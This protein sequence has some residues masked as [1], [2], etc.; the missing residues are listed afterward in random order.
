MA[1]ILKISETEGAQSAALSEVTGDRIGSSK[2]NISSRA[3]GSS[4]LVKKILVVTTSIVLML[5]LSACGAPVSGIGVIG[6]GI[7]TK[8]LLQDMDDRATHVIQNAAA[9][10][11]LLSSKAA[12]DVHLLIDAARQ[13]LHDE[14]DVQWD[15]LDREKVDFLREL[16]AEV[17]RIQDLGSQFGN[18]EDTAYL[19]TDTLASRLPFAQKMPRVRRIEGSSQYFKTDG[20]YKLLLTANLFEPFGPK[21]KVLVGN[22]MMQ[23][24][25]QPPYSATL[26]IPHEKLH[27]NDFQTVEVPL[28][29]TTE[30]AQKHFLAKNETH[31]YE[32]TAYIELYPK[33]P[34]YYQMDESVNAMVVDDTR[35]AVANG[36]KMLIPG[37]GDSGCNAYYNVCSPFPVGAQ[38]I[39]TVNLYD[40]FSGWGGF[41]AVSVGVGNVC[42]VY[43]QHSHNVARNV[44]IDVL[45]HP[46][47][48]E[49][50]HTPVLLQPVVAEKSPPPVCTPRADGVQPPPGESV[51]PTAVGASK[52]VCWLQ[53]GNT[54]LA[55]FNPNNRGYKLA[56]HMFNGENYAVIDGTTD[57]SHPGVEV[58]TLP[59]EN[60]RKS[61]FKVLEPRIH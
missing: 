20:D 13:N 2:M 44:S 34:A 30:I 46:L 43:W 23:V 32:F 27:F 19:D 54:Y 42:Q 8:L 31:V 5:N 25:Q 10:G 52:V 41:G 9:A 6:G 55:E 40:S 48:A 28:K 36:G 37:C 35:T 16:N 12:R 49:I 1:V 51:T 21:T 58:Q 50:Q 61:T 33:Y 59:G 17:D 11:S 14:L 45:Y 4:L 15:K 7:A 60:P 18:L 47:K 38:Y 24:T 56:V 22:E 53:F 29:I 26:T 57:K 39:Q 3:S